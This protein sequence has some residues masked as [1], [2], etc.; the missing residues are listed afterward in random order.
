[1]SND[2]KHSKKGICG[3]KEKANEP[4]AEDDSGVFYGK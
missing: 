1:M 3:K 2:D 4:K